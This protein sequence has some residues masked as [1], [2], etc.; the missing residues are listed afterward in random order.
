MRLPPAPLSR[1]ARLFIVLAAIWIA[2]MLLIRWPAPLAPVFASNS[3]IDAAFFAYAGELVRTGGTP[4][5]TFWDHKP[6][7]VYLIDAVGMAVGGGQVWG[8]WLMSLTALLTA[9]ALC[10][11]SLRRGLAT[12]GAVLGTAYFVFDLPTV[13]ASNLTEEYVLPLQWAAVAL[14]LAARTS[15]GEP[16]ALRR[17]GLVGA[18]LGVVAALSVLLRP[19]LIGGPLAAGLCLLLPALLRRQWGA[20]LRLVAGAVAAALAIL[21]ATVGWLASAGA[22]TAFRDQVLHYNALYVTAGWGQRLRASYVGLRAATSY[23]S[24]LIP[25]AGWLVAARMFVRAPRAAR[26]DPFLLLALLWPPLEMLLAGTSGRPY[27]H[28]FAPLIPPLAL[29][30]GVLGAELGALEVSRAGRPFRGPTLVAALALALALSSVSDV[31]IRARDDDRA[32]TRARQVATTAAYVATHT[33]PSDRLLVWGH[34]AD[35]HLFAHRR[36][37]SRFVYPLALLTPRYAD[38][39]LV[40]GFMA[41]VRQAAPPIIVDATPNAL[42]GDDLVP[43]LGAW[44]P[45]WTYPK[46]QVAGRRNWWTMTPALHEFY[47]WVRA[48]YTVTDSV[49]PDRWAIYTRRQGSVDR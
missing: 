47:D 26:L 9:L 43:P 18:G 12:A 33:R 11:A 34:A 5:L 41:E 44:N 48:N 39:A 23:G 46:T 45:A 16:A 25:L 35:V 31:V 3:P 38:T 22:L 6:P 28:Y 17:P 8:V 4:Y 37:A 32:R 21:A 2:V 42:A 14:L 15:P 49:G 10:W 24:L 36:P 30:A 1:R 19:N 27:G 20:A 40:R 7:L 13:L 29:L